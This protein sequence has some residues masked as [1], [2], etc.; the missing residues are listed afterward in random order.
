ML[1]R[2][3]NKSSIDNCFINEE[4]RKRIGKHYH[5]TGNC[6]ENRERK[7][8]EHITT[9]TRLVKMARMND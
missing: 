3:C 4:T 9:P 2:A 7:F 8:L 6:K 5:E 1:I